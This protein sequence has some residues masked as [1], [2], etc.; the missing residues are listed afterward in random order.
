MSP[1]LYTPRQV[2]LHGELYSNRCPELQ[3]HSHRSPGDCNPPTITTTTA[4]ASSSSSLPSSS[5]SSPSSA[6][7]DHPHSSTGCNGFNLC[8]SSAPF[9]ARFLLMLRVQMFLLRFLR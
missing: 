9:S 4:T 7:S 5:S 1:R 2:G 3:R 8:R 6:P